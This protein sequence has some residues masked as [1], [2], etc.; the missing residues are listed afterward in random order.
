MDGPPKRMKNSSRSDC[1]VPEFKQGQEEDEVA[2]LEREAMRELEISKEIRIQYEAEMEKRSRAE[3]TQEMFC[4][5]VRILP[6][7][8]HR[9]REGCWLNDNIVDAF[10]EIVTSGSSGSFVVSSYFVRNVPHYSKSQETVLYFNEGY[11][12]ARVPKLATY[13]VIAIPVNTC[14]SHWTL[15]V[16]DVRARTLLYLDSMAHSETSRAQQLMSALRTYMYRNYPEEYNDKEWSTIFSK[17]CALQNG[18]NDCGVFVCHFLK[19]CLTA[20]NKPANPTTVASPSIFS[21]RPDTALL[22]SEIHKEI[23]RRLQKIL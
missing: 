21:V 19:L 17:S 3:K 2:A 23:S 13:R 10:A 15:I 14:N 9:L 12:Q 20:A 7:D 1:S 4:G 18:T 5:S 16:I 11:L 6:T 8:L 22:R